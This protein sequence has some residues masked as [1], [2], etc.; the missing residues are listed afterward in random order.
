MSLKATGV[1]VPAGYTNVCELDEYAH[2]DI[3]ELAV[4]M[5]IEEY[6]YKMAN[7]E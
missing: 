6:K 1:G 5:F 2:Q 3:V 4:R 7:R